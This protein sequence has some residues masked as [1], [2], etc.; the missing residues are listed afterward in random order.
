MTAT[1]RVVSGA[2]ED[3]TR[4]GSVYGGDLLVFKDVPPLREFCAFADA[5]IREAFETEDPV[6]AQFGLGRDEYLSRV[7]ALQRRFRKD[8]AAKE[9]FLAALGHVGVDLRRTSWDW[10][11]LRVSPHG[12]EHAG[13]RTAKLGFH[14][15]TW[16]S[17]VYAQTNWWAPIYPITAGRTIAFYPAYWDEPLKNTS[18]EWDL[19]EIRAGGSSAPVVPGPTETVD[20][21]SELR[22]VIEPGDLLCFSGAHLHASVPNTTGVARF[23][24]EVRTV[25]TGDV[26]DGRGA[27][28]LDGEAPRVASGW[29]RSVGDGT[30]LPAVGPG[31]VTEPGV[32]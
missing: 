21:A 8:D 5:L 29:F 2:L 19:E 16:S 14:R 22:P 25:D 17:N 28:N 30:P 11:Y 26:A 32:E 13:R 20:T 1:V 10:L 6:R 3:G 18:R 7:E 31:L 9:L 27:P 15:D 23:S 24:V 12:D 4:R